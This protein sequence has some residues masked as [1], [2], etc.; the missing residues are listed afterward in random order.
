MPK[1]P[2]NPRV[3]AAQY[4]VRGV[5]PQRADII[6]GE[7]DKD[8][9]SH[10]FPRVTY[11]N[12][13]N[14]QQLDQRPLTFVRQVLSLMQYPQLIDDA[15]ALNKSVSGKDSLFPSDALERARFL[16][17]QIGSVGA[18]SHSKGVPVIRQAVADFIERR[19]GFPADPEDIFLSAGASSAVEKIMTLLSS[20][21]DKSGM[22]V[23]VPQYPLYTATCTLVGSEM[24]GYSLDEEHGWNTGIGAIEAT[25]NDAKARGISPRLLVVINPGNP[26]GSN[27][28]RG[29]I[30]DILKF[31]KERELLVIA[32]EVY[33]CNLFGKQ[34]FTSFKKVRSELA[35]EDP[36]YNKVALASLHSTSKGYLGECGQRGGYVEVVGFGDHAK[37]Q[38]YKLCSIGLCPVVT[39][40]V[41]TE[42]MI[43]PPKQGEPSY[44]LYQKERSEI[45]QRMERRG[46]QLWEAFHEMRGVS[47]QKPQGAMYLFP[48]ITLPERAIAEADKQGL[49]PD[50][51]YAMELLNQT[52]ICV[53]PGSGFGQEK[54]TFHFR[55][56]FLAPGGKDLSQRFIEFHNSFMDKYE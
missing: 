19:D 10:P 49:T 54:G 27:M 56:T 50:T 20:E 53:V 16:R 25:Y 42:I 23:P 40:Q 34:K 5:L 8:P 22:L 46:N 3:I 51:F 52:G 4:A 1:I 38:L 15:D 32:D 9:K 13:G 6:Q 47:C 37:E 33:Q 36:A 41:C 55:T 48:K 44:A 43:N 11:L 29:H 24:L 26:T 14:P 30:A 7:L 28:D 45:L 35:Q 12:I 31:A 39:G 17:E 21:D 2:I 18:Y